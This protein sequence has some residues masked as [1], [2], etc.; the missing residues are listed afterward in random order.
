MLAV[1]E[2][3]ANSLEAFRLLYNIEN[4]LREFIIDQMDQ[5]C[6]P[7]W[8]KT[9]L[10][11]DICKKY[12]EAKQYER[13][14]RWVAL[15]PHHQIY[16]LD[17][18]D[19][20]KIIEQN[21]NW[22]EVFSPVF[23]S[24]NITSDALFSI[25]PIRNAI[26]HNRLISDS[27]V[28][29][30]RS[31]H[32]RLLTLIGSE[33]C[34]QL[35]Q[36]TDKSISL[37][38]E[39]LGISEEISR[40]AKA[41]K[42]LHPIGAVSH[43][44]TSLRSWWF[45]QDY[46][47]SPIDKIDLY[48]RELLRYMQLPRGWGDGMAIERW[49][50][51]SE[52]SA[53][54]TA[55]E[56]QMAC[57]STGNRWSSTMNDRPAYNPYDFANPVTS[58]SLLAGRTK[59]REEIEYYLDHA[60][61]A[62]RPINV[63]LIGH[64]A[65][66]KTSLLN[67]TEGAAKR[68][69]FFTVRLDLDSDVASNHEIQLLC[70]A[71]FRRVQE[72]RTKKMA[73]G[74]GVLDDVRQE[75]AA[76]QNLSDRPILTSLQA[77][78]AGYRKALDCLAGC[79]RS[80]TFDDM[81]KFEF[82]TNGHEPWNR[83]QLYDCYQRLVSAGILKEESGKIIFNGDEFDR[84][85]IK[86]LT[87]QK[88]QRV[89]I[90]D[91]PLE[92]RWILLLRRLLKATEESYFYITDGPVNQVHA[93]TQ[94][95]VNSDPE[96]DVVTD[97]PRLE[98]S[99]FMAFLKYRKLQEFQIETIHLDQPWGNTTILAYSDK[100]TQHPGEPLMT[101]AARLSEVGG[102][103]ACEGQ[104]VKFISVDKLIANVKQRKN[105]RARSDI[106]NELV[107]HTYDDYLEK[108]DTKEA[109]FFGRLAVDAG[110]QFSTT[111]KNNIAYVAFANADNNLAK[112]LFLE[113]LETEPEFSLSRYNLAMVLAKEGELAAAIAELDRCIADSNELIGA[114]HG[115]TCLFAPVRNDDVL[116]ITEVRGRLNLQ[117]MA[118]AA[119]EQLDQFQ[120]AH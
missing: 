28:Q 14:V 102:G 89:V 118:V 39:F 52:F 78:D 46:L 53:I 79:C 40:T 30:M 7:R 5:Q 48:Y 16:Y 64:R 9:R 76:T 11:A 34:A 113:A 23:W 60:A 1:T 50:A 3:P 37:S 104:T 119:K 72:R 18:S 57:S 95:Y 65:S 109:F 2:P 106:A 56:E 35:L 36:R 41:V 85:Y 61:R 17:F 59:E 54:L 4:T 31:S 33:Y 45:D 83:D 15:V 8:H 62:P 115:A 105:E 111:D 116:E 13:R 93:V 58:M 70:H 43:L 47:G 19:L 101:L 99:I 24:K 29:Q 26:A 63:A 71:M 73:L 51:K 49:A 103:F 22:S 92:V 38:K 44:N 120:C 96:K 98:I 55:A 74:T 86:Y 110:C 82:L 6:G 27:D 117:K 12:S 10:P 25:E 88:R 100:N 66:G 77:L 68:R 69:G 81:W 94:W 108:K 114:E 21:N 87:S 107:S 75:L 80:A 97:A 42:A 20:R 32:Q 112:R 84:I 91:M 67:F 90:E